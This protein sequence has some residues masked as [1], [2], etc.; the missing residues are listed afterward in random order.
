MQAGGVDFAMRAF[1]EPSFLEDVTGLTQMLAVR[2]YHCA[3]CA[4]LAH[5]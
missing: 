4:V 3:H 1:N 5:S 2:R